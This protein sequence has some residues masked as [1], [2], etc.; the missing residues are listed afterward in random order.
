MTKE[1]INTVGMSY[2]RGDVFQIVEAHGRH[3]WIGAFV[4]AD[5]IRTWGIQ[6]YVHNIVT[7]EEHSTIWI[8]LKWEEIEYIGR[9]VLVPKEEEDDE[10]LGS[11]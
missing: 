5:E 3:G 10:S 2:K 1:L 4:M 6:G 11:E 9:A 8:R 7:H